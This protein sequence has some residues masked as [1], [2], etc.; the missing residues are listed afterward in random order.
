MMLRVC[1]DGEEALAEL[2]AERKAEITKQEK[3]TGE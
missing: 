1:R 3:I 2:S